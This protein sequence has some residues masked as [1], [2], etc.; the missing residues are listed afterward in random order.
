MDRNGQVT[1]D[2]WTYGGPETQEALLRHQGRGPIQFGR[3]PDDLAAK[4]VAFDADGRPICE[5]IEPIAPG[6]YDSF[7]GIRTA[8]RNA[9]DIPAKVAAAKAA[10]ETLDDA[11]FAAAMAHLPMPS[12]AAPDPGAG[13]RV[14]AGHFD[15]S[16]A[17][18]RTRA[19]PQDAAEVLAKPAP[20]R[21]DRQDGVPAEYLR[22]LDA[23]LAQRMGSKGS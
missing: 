14:V 8:K 11:E 17:A 6:A 15:A 5:G 7:E 3:N 9:K 13:A 19:G 2:G 23:H 10:S 20:A 1:V 16:L 4:A 21:A 18:R 12:D 22:N